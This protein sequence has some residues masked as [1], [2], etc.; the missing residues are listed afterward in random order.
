MILED[1]Y[2]CL[3]DGIH[4][5]PFCGEPVPCE[6]LLTGDTSFPVTLSSTG[7]VLIAAAK[8]GSGKMVVL[9][10][11]AY[12]STPEFA[13]FIQNAINWLKPSQ[14]SHKYFEN[15]L[16]DLTKAGVGSMLKVRNLNNT[17]GVLCMDA[18]D[19]SNADKLIKFVKGGGGLLI[20]G[21][22][23]WWSYAHGVENVILS[24]P[25]NKVTSVAGI[26][27]TS[28]Y[29]EKGI[30][31]LPRHM[32]ATPLL[33][34]HG[35]NISEHLKSLLSGITEL[36]LKTGGIPAPALVH[37]SL[38]F[39]VGL[40]DSLQ[41]YCA[42][43][44]YGKGR[45]VVVT[46]ESHQFEPQLKKFILNVVHWLGDGKKQL[47]VGVATDAAQV[48]RLLTAEGIRCTL[49]DLRPDM[50]IYC[51]KSYSDRQAD[52]IH[53]FVAEGGGL[54]IGGQAWWWASQNPG[55]EAAAEY[56]GNKI[57]NRFGMT[58]LGCTMKD[59]T[60]K[61]L[62]AED[63]CHHYHFRKALFQ[64]QQHLLSKGGA[65]SEAWLKQLRRDCKELLNIPA[66]GVASVLFIRKILAELVSRCENITK[67]YQTKGN[68]K[69][70]ILLCIAANLYSTG[71]G[72]ELSMFGSKE[73][74]PATF[75]VTINV[76]GTNKVCPAWRS[77]GL[78][79]FERE[80]AIIR[81]PECAVTADLQV[82]IGCH[83][84]D[85]TGCE[86][87]KRP[88]VV[89][90][91]FKVDRERMSVCSFWGGLIY[92]IIPKECHLGNI[93]VTVEGAWQAP[94]FRH[95]QTSKSEW[96]NTIR[97]YPGRWAE[98]AT[99]NLI[100][101][102]PSDQIRS[103]DNPDSVLLM[104]DKIMKGITELAATPE[105]FE[106]PERIVADI[107]I[108]CGWMHAGYPIMI[109]LDSVKEIT[110]VAHMKAHGLW[111]PIHELGHNQQRFGWEIPPH[112]TEATCNLWSVYIHEKVLGIPRHNAHGALQPKKRKAR[113][114]EYKKNGAALEKWH[115]WTCLE[116]YLQLQEGFGWDPFIH[117]FSEYQ[118]LSN[119]PKDNIYKMNLWAEKFSQCVKKN[120]APF[121]KAWG[122]PITEDV[123]RKLSSLP[124]WKD[125]PMM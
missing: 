121:F 47:N 10:H 125:N 31:S 99:E 90:Q 79:L 42:A 64:F 8:Y 74:H 97:H 118:N 72:Y 86:E 21:Q 33:V 37:G 101:T 98:L 19:D 50:N 55:C 49:S 56:P 82:Q 24:F 11:E 3:V 117:L 116:T 71:C 106:R 46:H 57:I 95:G 14:S 62:R 18:Y 80:T 67:I 25:G 83:S 17:F 103:L 7:Q 30:V 122:W 40:D 16:K 114:T 20:G 29:G 92:I 123:S 111:G 41:T 102:V 27:F 87:W 120:L 58:I 73:I 112:T 61:P 66:D 93:S 34:S 76:N 6:L 94:F 69:D 91:K 5:L 124:E 77:T 81:F 68:V 60:Y 28:N 105:T 53:E 84:D 12:I 78:Y 36:N 48:H 110:D 88:P 45:V 108:S 22:A 85:L 13:R 2:R 43:A 59:T 119:I 39:S 107:Q 54:F 35:L 4:T 109:H 96:L 15:T 75:P 70:E 113:I 52:K 51:C 100:L 115:V 9:S 63:A 65:P 44:L 1:D 38:A 26:Y 23:W 104:W 32:P 89:I